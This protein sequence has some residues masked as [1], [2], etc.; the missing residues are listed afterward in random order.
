MK[1]ISAIKTTQVKMLQEDINS[2]HKIEN[3]AL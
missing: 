3:K 2:D 1:D